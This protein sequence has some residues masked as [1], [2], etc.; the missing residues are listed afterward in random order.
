[1]GG[2]VSRVVKRH[3]PRDG[4]KYV[5][6]TTKKSRNQPVMSDVD[7]DFVGGV[8]VGLAHACR[9]TLAERG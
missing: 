5:I 2:F 8:D 4:I 1:M 7:V 6:P 9:D 3:V